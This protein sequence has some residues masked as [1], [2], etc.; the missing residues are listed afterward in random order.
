MKIKRITNI[1]IGEL[2]TKLTKF[3]Q[4]LYLKYQN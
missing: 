1:E 2:K 4:N 3:M